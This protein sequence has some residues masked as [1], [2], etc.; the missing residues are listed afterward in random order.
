[1]AW[2]NFVLLGLGGLLLAVPI[3]LHFLMQPEPKELP[4]PALRFVK[5]S[6]HRNRSRMRL[7]HLL[8][9]LLRCLLIALLTLAL[10]GPSVA[11]QEFGNWLTLGGIGFSGF[12]VGL[13]LAA[14]MWMAKQRNMTLVAILGILFLAHLIYG[15]WSAFKLLNS[16]SVQLIG[17]SQAPIAALV[18]V[19]TSPRMLYTN[20]NKS[21][22][23][24][25]KEMG[26]WLL[27]QFPADS[28]VCVM[29]TDND[30]PF[31]SVDVSSAKKRLATLDITYGGSFVPDSV[32]EGIKLLEK[33]EQER[34]EVYVL[35]DLTARSW[36]TENL[37]VSR[38]LMKKND[39]ITAFVI[40]VGV[41][42]TQNFLLAT[43]RLESELIT[44]TSGL[45]LSSE[46]VRI[47]PAAQRTVRMRIEKPDKKKTLPVIR[48]GKTITPDKFWE[49]S[50]TVDVRENRSAN[51]KF[52]FNEVLEPGIYHGTIDVVGDDGLT[53]D[54]TRFFT[55]SVS[56]AFNVL[57]VHPDDVKPKTVLATL[58]PGGNEQSSIFNTETVLQR[59]L[60][61]EFDDYQ[62][63][64]FLDPL[65]IQN[66]TW[67]AL[68][69]YANS[70]GGVVFF[71]GHNA[72]SGTQ[73]HQSFQTENAQR[74]L[75]G[76]ITDQ[77]RRPDRKLFLS[78]D[79]LSHPIFEPFRTIEMNVPWH[80]HS[81]MRFWG[82]EFDALGET[83]PTQ[84]LLRYG[85]GLP[86]LIER[87]IGHG[88]VLVMTT[89]VTEPSNSRE[90]KI[91]NELFLGDAWPAWILLS[92]IGEHLI[93]SDAET[94]NVNV[95]QTA[96]LRN[97]WEVHPDSYRVFTPHEGKSPTQ[98]NAPDNQLRYKFTDIPG[99][100]RLKGKLDDQ[101]VLRGFSA[102]LKSED[103]DLARIE[104]NFLDD[105]FGFERYKI[106]REKK[107][108]TRQ[109]GTTRRGQEFYPL[110]VLMMVVVFALEFL[111][112]NRFYNS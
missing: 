82:F 4:F 103:T 3:V 63:V 2:A 111:M 80:N 9:L 41:E 101:P 74:V 68:E 20:E 95:G 73:A 104:D 1:M 56:Q 66:S 8:L 65:P 112:S 100:F 14:S 61:G 83:Y 87:Q 107:Q 30:T 71:L 75:S 19:D 16:S 39:G 94:L 62:A 17:D 110:L 78:P 84:T 29:A 5:K 25:A 99:H 57:I 15:G 53:V 81:V 31:F 58:T 38:E 10:A 40:D 86:A 23:E 93:Q 52:N 55:V 96:V 102:N 67:K 11:S 97:K 27:S 105:V 90:R 106:A 45:R 48:D 108:I 59:N 21:R 51:V 36:A 13:I 54:D 109:Q 85:N 46:L 22:I 91:W 6:E 70:G 98:I 33:A 35:T 42:S 89:P 76:K 28:Q 43:P 49:R 18:V 50:V 7:R 88:R 26:D 34:K 44:R 92:E 32:V 79:N 37:S 24:V 69:N 60:T 64:V 77:W 12:V 47:G 72:A